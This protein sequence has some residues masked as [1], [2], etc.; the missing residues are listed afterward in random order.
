MVSSGGCQQE[1]RSV[2]ATNVLIAISSMGRTRLYT[3]KILIKNH[4]KSVF[5]CIKYL[6]R[7]AVSAIVIK[8]AA[9]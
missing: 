6:F 9:K 2:I 4:N 8:L 1:V 7:A 5:H 3:I